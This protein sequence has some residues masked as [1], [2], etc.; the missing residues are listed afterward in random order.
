MDV[1]PLTDSDEIARHY[2]EV[3]IGTPIE[4][5][6]GWHVNLMANAVLKEFPDDWETRAVTKQIGLL[7]AVSPC[8]VDLLAP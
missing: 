6:H 2:Y 4:E 3:H 1:D 7:E 5:K 8:P